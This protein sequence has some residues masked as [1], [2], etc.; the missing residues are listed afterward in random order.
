MA[1]NSTLDQ[2]CII[3]NADNEPTLVNGNFLFALPGE[4][5]AINVELVQI[6]YI[7]IMTHDALVDN[8]KRLT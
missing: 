3:V 8:L 1:S 6:Q 5:I 7:I 2:A 4:F